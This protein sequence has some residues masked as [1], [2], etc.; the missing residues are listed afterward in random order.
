MFFYN[1]QQRA[2]TELYV[3]TFVSAEIA[4]LG[5]VCEWMCDQLTGRINLADTNPTAVALEF[6]DLAFKSASSLDWV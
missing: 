2:S 6:V 3:C 1:Q 5:T 4:I